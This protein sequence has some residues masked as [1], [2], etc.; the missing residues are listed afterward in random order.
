PVIRST[1]YVSCERQMKVHGAQLLGF[2]LV[3]RPKPRPSRCSIPV[4]DRVTSSLR[5][6]R[7]SPHCDRVKNNCNLRRRLLKCSARTCTAL[8]SMD[9]AFKSRPSPSH[10]AHGDLVVG[11]SYPYLT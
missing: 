3:G 11:K 6:S 7:Y 4:A 2:F 8:R 10:S 1:C 5:H 9:D